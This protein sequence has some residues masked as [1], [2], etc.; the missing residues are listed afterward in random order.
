MASI[1][2]AQDLRKHLVPIS[3]LSLDPANIRLHDQRSIDA[4][5][6]SLRRFGQQKP[7]VVDDRGVVVAGNGLLQ[8]AQQLKMTQVA[9]VRSGLAGVERIAYAIADNRTAEL[10]TWD[11]PALRSLL[12]ATPD[13]LAEAMG[14]SKDELAAL[15][16]PD[17]I[18]GVHQDDIPVVAKKA[19]SKRGDVWLLGGH[20]LMCG[21]S[22]EPAD[23][24]KVMAGEKASLFATDPP[25]LVGYDGTNHPQSFT[26]GKSKD[27]SATYGQSWDEFDD[28][29]KL[30]DEFV[31]AAKP[32]LEEGAAWY[33]WYAS[34]RHVLLEKAW[35]EAGVL[36]HCQIIWVKNRPILTRTWFLWQH[37]PCLMGWLKGKKPGRV[38]TGS[39]PTTVWTFDTL[40][41]DERPEHPTPK[42]IELF[43][44]PIQE[45]VKP[46]GVCFEPFSGSGTQIIAAE[47][48]G[49]RCFAIDVQPLYVDVA[50]RRWEKLTGKEAVLE[51]TKLT[52]RQVARQRGVRLDDACPKPPSVPAN[53]RAAEPSSTA[54][55]ANST[56][57][58]T[59]PKPGRPRKARPA[60]AATARRGGG[61]AR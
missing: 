49:R 58:S 48:L 60:P 45:H 41:N 31:A 3:K 1:K 51:G 46:G 21:S 13:D 29:S 25:Y 26:S 5:A 17:Q 24:A 8:A 19:V 27:W 61:S 55:T 18:T 22:T 2:I 20:R 40:P 9:A 28:N 56:K 50:V 59:S 39:R 54:A 12:E 15:L 57:P 16:R 11:E 34:R 53:T 6:S 37:E 7:V 35:T 47:Q 52:W 33:C 30:Y 14:Y 36:P 38:G 4:I 10:S 43:A 42:P 23:V 32:H 44:I